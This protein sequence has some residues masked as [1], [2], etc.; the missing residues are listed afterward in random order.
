MVPPPTSAHLARPHA[1]LPQACSNQT[2]FLPT[3]SRTVPVPRLRCIPPRSARSRAGRSRWGVR[4][5]ST[6]LVLGGRGVAALATIS[7][8]V[9]GNAGVGIQLPRW[10][11][12]GAPSS[13]D[14][15]PNVVLTVERFGL[16]L[17]YA[18]IRAGIV[19]GQSHIADQIS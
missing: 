1:A 5:Q 10:T 8:V 14:G 13:A 2:H 18:G 6:I 4:G 19:A 7:E 9:G 3:P 11:A 12:L 17:D 16:P 15:A